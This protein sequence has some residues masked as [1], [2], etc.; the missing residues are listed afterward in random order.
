MSDDLLWENRLSGE[1]VSAASIEEAQDRGRESLSNPGAWVTVDPR[2]AV[3]SRLAN[4][5]ALDRYRSV[6]IEE[7]PLTTSQLRWLATADREVLL[8]CGS[9]WMIDLK[10][11]ILSTAEEISES[12]C[13]S[14]SSVAKTLRSLTSRVVEHVGKNEVTAALETLAEAR[15]L[16]DQRK[17]Q[18]G[19]GQQGGKTAKYARGIYD[20]LLALGPLVFELSANELFNRFP[21]SADESHIYRDGDELTEV[22]LESGQQRTLTRKSFARYVTR[23]RA[24]LR[25][26][27][28]DV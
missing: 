25:S 9:A 18:Q 23:A 16:N 14:S 6:F 13:V 19:T 1:V 12:V 5:P 20:Y 2:D 21:D 26:T 7:P 4:D 15:V 27:N 11:R 22:D 8:A 3:E 17:E 28:E 24:E 10:E